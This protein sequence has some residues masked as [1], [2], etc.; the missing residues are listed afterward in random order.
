VCPY[1]SAE[2]AIEENEEDFNIDIPGES[3]PED[4]IA[5]SGKSVWLSPGQVVIITLD[6]DNVNTFTLTELHFKIAG[7]TKA[8]INLRVDPPYAPPY[9]EKFMVRYMAVNLVLLRIVY[10]W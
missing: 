6:I 3:S 7:A 5:G 2:T 10:I 8:I 9:N 1:G 4:I